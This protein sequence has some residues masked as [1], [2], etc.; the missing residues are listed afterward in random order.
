MDIFA[1]DLDGK[2]LVRLTDTPGYD[3]EGSYSADG[4]QIVFTSF[5]DGDGEIYIMDADGKN[6]RRITHAKGYDGGPFFSPDG[7]RII[8]R[9][10]RK[11]NDLLQI[12]IN[13][14]EGTAERALT[15]N[16]FVNWGPYWHPDGRHIIYATSKH[17]HSQLRALPDGR[18]Q[19]P[20]RADHLPRRIRRP[21]GF[22][23]R[24]QAADVDFERPDR[25]S[26]EPALHRGFQPEGR[27]PRG[28][29]CVSLKSCMRS[30]EW[31]L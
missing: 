23:P 20:G 22:Q 14:T 26:Q 9:S 8:Y 5:R 3:A 4:S 29:G 18:G 12:Y 15:N 19:R 28:S 31:G 21:A 1:A 10:D 17:G 25:R 11:S 13:N 30:L 6:P 7:K 16:E 2:H 24:R 27:D